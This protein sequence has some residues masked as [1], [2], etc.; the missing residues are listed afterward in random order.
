MI[1]TIPA[2]HNKYGI[3]LPQN[4][5]LDR[6]RFTDLKEDSKGN[7]RVLNT[8]QNLADL[9]QF[10][11]LGFRLNMMTFNN[12]VC[13]ML[14][15]LIADSY[16]SINSKLISAANIYGL[17]EKAITTHLVALC[18]ETKYHP[19][20]LYL[21]GEKWD[22]K[23]RVSAVIRCLNAKHEAL[24]DTILKHWLV[25]CVASLYEKNFNSKLVPVLQGDQSF[26]KTA[27][28][29]RFAEIIPHAFLEGAALNP[30]DKDSVLSCIRSFIVELGELE[31]TSKNSQGSLK[32]FITNKVDTVRPPYARLDIKKPRQTHFIATVNGSE[33]LKD[34]TGSSRFAVIEME[35]A[36]NMNK[37]NE[38]LGWHYDGTGSLKQ[39]DE[40]QLKQ[41]WLEVKQL[42]LDGHGWMLKDHHLEQI[43]LVNDSYQDKGF[44]YGYIYDNYIAPASMI[45]FANEID[46]PQ[47]INGWFTAGELTY[48]DKKLSSHSRIIVGKA[49]TQLSR[50]GFLELKKAGGNKTR[51]KLIK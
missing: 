24:A 12:E 20:K 28:V 4:T 2:P 35:Q 43:A 16:D 39:I 45:D 17:P 6:P 50:E 11:S 42:Y 8:N 34:E 23:E 31:R 10:C 14:G 5:V 37:L 1:D 9:A 33:F 21:D 29:S 30:D 32:A 19:V 40:S 27:F 47:C 15:N 3:D 44:A 22:G 51:Y 48:E 38:L 49:L 13:D 36:A 46:R 7:V 26:R 25:G 18:E 41:F